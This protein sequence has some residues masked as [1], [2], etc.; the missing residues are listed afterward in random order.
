[1]R[2]GIKMAKKVEIQV[3]RTFRQ[4]SVRV[5]AEEHRA[6]ETAAAKLGLRGATAFMRFA[7]LE[8][9]ALFAGAD[10]ERRVLALEQA[11][12]K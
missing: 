1:M 4:M 8:K 7:A 12:K 9:A 3:K 5:S 2:Y 6:L 11:A 10:L